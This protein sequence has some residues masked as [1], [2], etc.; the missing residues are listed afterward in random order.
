VATQPIQ[1]IHDLA[2]AAFLTWLWRRDTRPGITTAAYFIVYGIGRG[3]I[4]I[5]RGDRSRGLYFGNTVSTSQLLA[6]A[7]VVAGL[8]LIWRIRHT[9]GREGA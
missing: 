9:A 2:L 6:I 7:S 1:A 5:W 4:E 8:L 3:V